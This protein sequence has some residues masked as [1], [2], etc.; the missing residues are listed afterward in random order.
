MLAIPTN[1]NL[2]KSKTTHQGSGPARSRAKL[3]Y[4][5]CKIG[6]VVG[7]QT[8]KQTNKEKQLLYIT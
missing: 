5:T 1:L 4:E 8:N 6:R 7:P 2:N 3:Q